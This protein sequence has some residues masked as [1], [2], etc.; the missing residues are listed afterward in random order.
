[1]KNKCILPMLAAMALLASCNNDIFIDDTPRDAVEVAM[2]GDGGTAEVPVVRK[3]LEFISFDHYDP[4]KFVTTYNHNGVVIPNESPLDEIARI[5]LTSRPLIFDIYVE[6]DRLRLHSTE[7]T[8]Y[9]GSLELRL[10]YGYKLSFITVNIEP[11]CRPEIT[12]FAYDM[13]RLD[14][15][16]S[17]S[18]QT[19][20]LSYNNGGS[21]PSSLTVW[22][23]LNSFCRATL[24]PDDIW[25]KYHVIGAPL[26]LYSETEGWKITDKDYA[27]KTGVNNDFSLPGIDRM[28][29]VVVTVPAMSQGTVRTF[30]ESRQATV[31]FFM[32][33]QN[34]VS[35]REFDSE[36][37]CTVIQPLSYEVVID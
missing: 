25:F 5:N 9:I 37:L 23:Y 18:D 26:P 30:V 13:N 35:G 29:Q 17:R 7:C 24:E 36:G 1:M 33:M 32:T 31:P 2:I 12:S 6:G 28:L 27:L 8:E 21:L 11:G 14:D 19:F 3:G 22:P 10:D 20:S 34:P 15:L 16:G 4:D